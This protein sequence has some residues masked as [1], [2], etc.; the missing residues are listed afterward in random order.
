MKKI[1]LVILIIF[2]SGNVYSSYSF[3]VCWPYLKGQIILKGYSEAGVKLDDILYSDEDDMGNDII[4]IGSDLTLKVYYK[5]EQDIP[6][7]SLLSFIYDRFVL[8]WSRGCLDH[9]Q[10][11]CTDRAIASI[12][13]DRAK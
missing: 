9:F 12:Q 1:K 2:F 4:T 6:E 13:N 3:H 8:L 5:G 11:A 10:G 7:D